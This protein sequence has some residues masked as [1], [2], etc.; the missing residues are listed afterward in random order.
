[1][2]IKCIVYFYHNNASVARKS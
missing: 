2:N 1:M